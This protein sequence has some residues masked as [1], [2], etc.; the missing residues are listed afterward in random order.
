MITVADKISIIDAR[1]SLGMTQE[2]LATRSMLTRRSISKAE[3]GNPIRKLSAY[4]I[5]K[6]INEERVR[7]GLA[8]L[9]ME[10]LDVRIRGDT[11]K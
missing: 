8:P 5:L 6:A 7:Q 3:Q 11:E 1:A 4:A 10:E 9:E 2:Q